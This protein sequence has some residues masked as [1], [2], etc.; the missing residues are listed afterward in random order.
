MRNAATSTPTALAMTLII[1]SSGELFI[2]LRLDE[3]LEAAVEHAFVV[4]GH[5]LGIHHLRVDAITMRARLEHDPRER[6]RLAGLELD[7]SRERHAHLHV[8]VVAD[9]FPVLEG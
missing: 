5:G 7:A 9:T 8:Q 6:H 4:E 1:H 2:A 3:D